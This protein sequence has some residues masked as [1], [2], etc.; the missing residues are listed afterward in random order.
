MASIF[1]SSD[2]SVINLAAPTGGVTVDVPV[3]IGGLFGVPITTAAVGVEFGLQIRG[4]A[5]LP[6]TSAL[7]ISAGDELFWDKTNSVVNTTSNGQVPVATATE[8]AA[9]PSSTVQAV[10]R[11]PAAGGVASNF[12]QVAAGSATIAEINADY[13]IIPGIPGTTVRVVGYD[14]EAVGAFSDATSVEIESTNAT[15]VV[16]TS[17][18]VAAL[19]DGDLCN[20]YAANN[21]PGAGWLVSL[22]SGDGVEITKTGSDEA[23]ATSLT[24]AVQYIRERV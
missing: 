22:G 11:G 17:I 12:V 5:D 23:T 2:D 14:L 13:T 7:A 18:A 4:E 20:P 19:G 24:Y 6:K 15:P 21:T 9:N 16:V 10:L 3:L 8:A 1:T